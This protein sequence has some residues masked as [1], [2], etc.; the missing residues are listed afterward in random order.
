MNELRF[1][2]LFPCLSII[3]N[4]KYVLFYS[5]V[6]RNCINDNKKFNLNWY[7]NLNCIIFSIEKEKLYND[8]LDCILKR[9]VFTLR[10]VSLLFSKMI[11][12][13]I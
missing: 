12:H 2:T 3:L 6:Q 8:L 1:E 5:D 11:L 7:N 9:E 10:I 13:I 4:K